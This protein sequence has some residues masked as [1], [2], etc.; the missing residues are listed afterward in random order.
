M[1]LWL[2]IVLVVLLVLAVGGVIARQ[3]QLARTQPHFDEHLA[4]VN[5]ELAAALAQDRGWEPA[6]LEAA[7]RREWA[8]RREGAE[9]D[10][11]TLFEVLDRPGTAED[12]AVFRF[13]CG[14]RSELLTL[15][16]RDGGEWT[17]EALEDHAA[18]G[19][20]PPPRSG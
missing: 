19:A 5:R 8:Q 4:R 10:E 6:G 20:P 7:A 12:R 15:G 11:V 1:P 9:P 14:A 17:F 13:R 2:I 3:R 18:G 16:R